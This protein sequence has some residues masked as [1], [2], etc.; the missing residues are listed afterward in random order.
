MAKIKRERMIG[1]TDAMDAGGGG[2]RS[3]AMAAAGDFG[4]G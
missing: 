2:W 4:P 1:I 3:W